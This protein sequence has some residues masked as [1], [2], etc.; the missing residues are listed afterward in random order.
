MT[1]PTHH[2]LL[3]EDNPDDAFFV[4]RAF[5]K[6]FADVAVHILGDGEAA[7]AYL[8]RQGEYADDVRHPLP[9]LL[10]LD[11]KLPRASGFEVLTW[12]RAQPALRRLPVVVL[13]SSRHR[14]DIDRAYDLGA[15]SYL[16]KPVSTDAAR[17]ISSAMGLYWLRLNEPPCLR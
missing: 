12:L 6:A 15:N 7:I 17:E 9:D 1:E 2:V 4:E 14:Q 5:R 16:V 13:T 3:V 10:V 11:L 8:S